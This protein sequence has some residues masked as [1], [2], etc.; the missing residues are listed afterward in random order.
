MTERYPSNQAKEDSFVLPLLESYTMAISCRSTLKFL[1]AF[2]SEMYFSH[3]QFQANFQ[4]WCLMMMHFGCIK[5]DALCLYQNHHSR[6]KISR[7]TLRSDWHVYTQTIHVFSEGIFPI[8]TY[9][10]F[11]CYA[12]GVRNYV[13]NWKPYKILIQ[14]G[15]EDFA[16][17]RQN[18]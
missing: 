18:I 16:F 5:D 4:G 11:S 6:H 13:L 8:M 2:F 3:A 12:L 17:L 14:T 9:C 7:V 1:S 10:K 15:S